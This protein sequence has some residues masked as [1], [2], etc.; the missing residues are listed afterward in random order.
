MTRIALVLIA[1]ICAVVAP[2]VAANKEIPITTS[3]KEALALFEKGQFFLDVGRP[4]EAN[5]L[6]KKALQLDPTFAY[7]HFNK[8]LSS[9]SAPE[10]KQE[11]DAA[12]KNG[13]TD[14]E[15]LLA[16][17][18]QTFISNDAK[19]RIE[20]SE[21]LVKQYPESPR[22]WLALGGSQ[23]SLNQNEQRGNHLQKQWN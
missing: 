3:S 18:S 23:G 1:L 6:F 20:L 2:A 8:A 19:K 7:A 17:I 15:K 22:A 11:L 9:A 10:F 4:Q 12:I 14:G 5:D 21:Q 13:K 16:E